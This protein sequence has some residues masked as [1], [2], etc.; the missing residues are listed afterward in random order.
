[1]LSALSNP[2]VGANR[3]PA[4]PLGAEPQ[5]GSLF[6]ARPEL[7]APMGH[8]YRDQA[9]KRA[10]SHFAQYSQDHQSGEWFRV[11]DTFLAETRVQ[12]TPGDAAHYGGLI[13]A[14]WGASKLRQQPTPS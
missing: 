9:W 13:M 3:R 10:D 6:S 14:L 7:P 4:S 2:P 5:F 1:M 8:L 11:S 12:Q